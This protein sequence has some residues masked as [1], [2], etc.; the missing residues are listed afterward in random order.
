MVNIGDNAPNFKAIALIDNNE[1]KISLSDFKGKKTALY[2]YPKDLTP[3]CTI[4]AE[5]LR[6]NYKELT[7]KGI[8]VIGVSKDPIKSHIKFSEKKELPFILISD[9]NLEINKAYGVWQKKKFMGREYMGTARTTFLIDEKGKIVN[10]V[11]KPVV[12]E[13]S[14]EIIDGFN[15]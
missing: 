8:V 1:K 12:K 2:F 6:D 13:H 10:I 3:G 7:K 5:N 11:D 4:Q 9:E 14:K 15:L